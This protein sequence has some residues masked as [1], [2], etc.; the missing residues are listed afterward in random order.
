MDKE[1]ITIKKNETPSGKISVSVDEIIEEIK[2]L[3]KREMS[4]YPNN[5]IPISSHPSFK[6]VIPDWSEYEYV[7]D[8]DNMEDDDF[9]DLDDDYEY[10]EP[11]V[12]NSII[13]IMEVIGFEKFFD[14]CIEDGTIIIGRVKKGGKNR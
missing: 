5:V 4:S 6:R 3:D 9:Y 10:E 7:D 14:K 1:I 8:P 2:K 11:G 12:R 13:K